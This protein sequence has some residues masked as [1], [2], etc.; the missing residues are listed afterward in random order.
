MGQAVAP[1]FGA[2]G[3]KTSSRFLC[4]L[5]DNPILLFVVDGLKARFRWLGLAFLLLGNLALISG[6]VAF[7]L[8]SVCLLFGGLGRGDRR[9]SSGGVTCFRGLLL[10]GVIATGGKAEDE[11]CGYDQ[12][13]DEKRVGRTA[14]GALH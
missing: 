3:I 10:G 1:L 9:A 7:F 12:T 14:H 4:V 2:N 8:L 13:T 11:Q 6:A 5:L